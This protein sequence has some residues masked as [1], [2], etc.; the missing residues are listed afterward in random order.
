[1]TPQEPRT[2]SRRH[3]QGARG[4]DLAAEHLHALGF[5]VLARDLR[6]RSAE[7]DLVAKKRSLLVAVEVKTRALHV[8]PERL[9]DAARVARLEAALRELAPA[10]A[11]GTKQLRVDV[12]AVRWPDDLAPDAR[13]ELL[14]L[15]GSPFPAQ[16][17]NAGRS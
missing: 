17:K 14:H 13:P 9:V 7:L 5:T 10:I 16:P 15:T 6:T 8:A 11:P 12:I 4:E 2:R 1:M 3:A